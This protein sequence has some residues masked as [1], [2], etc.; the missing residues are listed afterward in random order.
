MA[1]IIVKLD[2][3]AI[4]LAGRGIFDD[5]SWEIQRGQRVGLV[6]PNGAGKSTLMK[7][8]AQELTPD[9]GTIFRATGLTWGRLEQEPALSPGRTVLQEALSALPELATI[10]QDLDTLTERMAQPAVYGDPRALEKALRAQE[11]L[12]HRFEQLDGLRYESKVKEA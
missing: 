8:V 6:G 5:L 4:S 7:L 1:E 12:L 2:H 9:A 11:R 3:V 10:E